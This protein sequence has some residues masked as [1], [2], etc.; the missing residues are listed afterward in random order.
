MATLK[1]SSFMEPEGNSSSSSTVLARIASGEKAA[2]AECLDIYGGLV[3]SMAR[4][5][6]RN[7]V[8]AEDATQDVFIALW[9]NAGRFDPNV[10]SESVFV[11]MIA[12]RRLIDRLRKLD[13][14]HGIS[15]ESTETQP[16]AKVE[17]NL[18]E[19][20]DEAAKAASCLEHLSAE[21]KRILT[22]SIHEG[23]S[24]NEISQALRMPLGTVKSFARRGLIQL[25]EC[26]NRNS[27]A[28]VSESRT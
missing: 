22:L 19:L 20:A 12:R 25:R 14:S 8:D 11:A 2:V 24:H 13:P 7:Q 3:W 27:Q 17:R 18:A 23:A 28:H 6:F 1:Q 5:W 9:Q 15:I 4:K 26:M 21:Q 16:V 10:A